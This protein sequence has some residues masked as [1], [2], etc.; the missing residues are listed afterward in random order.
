MCYI[1]SLVH[2]SSL[3]IFTWFAYHSKTQPRSCDYIHL[4]PGPFAFFCIYHNL[5][6]PLCALLKRLSMHFIYISFH[7]LDSI[8]MNWCIFLETI[9][10]P[11]SVCPSAKHWAGKG[12][13]VQEGR[14]FLA[15]WAAEGN[16]QMQ[17]YLSE[18]RKY[19]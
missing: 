18:L 9:S 11:R 8:A 1:I 3:F 14:D 13:P 16:I 7:E 2:G 5:L 4:R 19:Q 10:G 6:K 17:F 15:I 12:V